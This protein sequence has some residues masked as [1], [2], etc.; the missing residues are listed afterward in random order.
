MCDKCGK[1][2]HFANRCAKVNHAA[3]T[4]LC[5]TGN[6]DQPSDADNTG[7]GVAMAHLGS[8]GDDFYD[9]GEFVFLNDGALAQWFRQ[10][11]TANGRAV[12][13]VDVFY[14]KDLHRDIREAPGT[15]RIRC[16]TGVVD[17]KM[18]GNPTGYP[19]P[20]WYYPDGIANILS[21]HCVKKHCRVQYDSVNEPAAFHVMKPDGS[22]RDFRTVLVKR[23]AE[24]TLE[25]EDSLHNANY[26][27]R[28]PEPYSAGGVEDYNDSVDKTGND[29]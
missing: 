20:V 15:Y 23:V 2:G 26:V 16:N 9:I 11:K 5:T 27:N 21:L 6:A 10:R 4:V 14:S 29:C 25:N 7:E 1:I 18:I 28:D 24:D 13:K 22:V 17:V 3:G 12:P 19:A 8:A